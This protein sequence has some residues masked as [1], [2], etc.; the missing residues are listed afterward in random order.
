MTINKVNK[1]LI[2]IILILVNLSFISVAAFGQIFNEEQNPL[3][4]KW[5]QINTSD[6]RIIYPSELEKE[7]QRLANT[8]SHIY[9]SIG[10]S[11]GQQKTSIP[12]V[13]QNRG[14]VANG[15]VQL[16]PKKSEFYTTPPQQFDSQD[17]LNN[18]T[19]HELRHVAQFD[20]LTGGK[21]HPFPEDI[22]FAW[23][24][25]SIPIW[26]FEGD[27]VTIETALTE[28]GR[29]RQ[30]AWIM[31]YR[32]SLLEGKKISYSKAYFGSDKD[33]TPG[34]YQ[35]G[36]LMASNIRTLHGKNI[37]DSVLTD[38]RKRPVRLYPFSN[39]LK[40][41]TGAGTGTWFRRTSGLIEKQWKEQE[42]K[43]ISKIYPVLNKKAKIATDYFLPVRISDGHILAIKRS[44][45]E[46]DHLVLI[47]SN[48]KERRLQGISYQ[49]Q[50]W[51]SYAR[52][53]VVW[54][55]VRY[56]PRY[57]QRN[58]SVIC[59]YNLKT[60]RTKKLSGRSRMFSPTLSADGK[61]IVAVKFD[62][63]NKCNLVELDAQTGK[64][65]NTLANP[66]NLILQTPAYDPSGEHITYVSV[67]EQGKA[68]WTVDY[69]GN[70]NKIINETRQQL[71]R[72]IYFKR[73]IAFNAHY[74]GINNIYH[75]D[76]TSKKIIALSAS[77]Y[78]AFNMTPE[79]ADEP[80]SESQAFLFNN[81]GVAGYEI[82]ESS[83][84]ADNKQPAGFTAR[85][86]AN[87]VDFNLATEQQE[88]TGT[89]FHDL[90]D[91]S[92]ASR[93]YH[94]LGDLFNVHSIIPIIQDEYMGGLQLKSNNLLNTFDFFA[95]A[96]YHRDLGRFEYSSGIAY[97]ALYP[98]IRGTYRNRPL[99]TFYYSKT[100][101]QQGDWRENT[102][103]LQASL[104]ISINAL[105]DTYNFSFNTI[106]SYTKRYMA[107]NLPSNFIKSVIFPVEYNFTFT[108]TT[109]LAD[110]DLA[111]KWAQIFR[112]VYT[113]QPFD[114]RLKGDLFAAE[115]FLYFPGILKNHS[116]LVNF[117]YQNSS[118][119]RKYE[120]EINTVYGYNNIMAK[121][122]LSNT[123]LFNYRFPFAFP[124]TEIGSLAY[125]KNLRA[126]IF[127]H[128][129]NLGTETDLSEPKTY[130][131]ELRSSLNLLRYQPLVD[132]GARFVFINKIYNQNP[133][134]ELIFNY[135]F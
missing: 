22:Y 112:T 80:N 3:S 52:D 49:E 47:D 21:A 79:T 67:S 118:G 40:K 133:I 57:R 81:Y 124:D 64:V 92:Y 32:T 115:G 107:E 121:S 97:K 6:F 56:D 87:F 117:N 129:E 23:F 93:P 54:D 7:A 116:F 19:V 38:I 111:P 63:T 46:A 9:P 105:S 74:N 10:F 41:F 28:S 14:V 85:L 35:L 50:P 61:K 100:G 99:R 131:F 101:M 39:S 43:T 69:N 130:G 62:L 12:I 103:Q 25:V 123:L 102:V 2:I 27:A 48:K 109:R 4:V 91:S 17:W 95:E 20:K 5:K 110:R 36:Y 31:P 70:T 18:L 119:I 8:I 125:I 53:V 26:F 88:A 82:A 128:F 72:P 59:S 114:S 24:G 68:M 15:F 55:E 84:D 37:F 51:F 13:L 42:Q 78:G 11:L 76:T 83:A 98:I 108:H 33:V 94:T 126:G 30:P 77:K 104:P 122:T 44:K 58:Y 60:R 65:I 96:D 134:L 1:I 127:C 71:S 34:Y 66:E 120:Q 135:S 113:H 90:P 106:T 89:V 73:G 86:P 29:G 75:I 16:A 45:A 132:V